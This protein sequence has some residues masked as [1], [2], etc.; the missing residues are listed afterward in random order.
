M[1]RFNNYQERQ[2]FGMLIAMEISLVLKPLNY[3]RLIGAGLT[4]DL[5]V[6]ASPTILYVPAIYL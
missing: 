3:L 4:L 2:R 6:A 5:M 1:V